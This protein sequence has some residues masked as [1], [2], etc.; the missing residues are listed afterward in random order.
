MNAREFATASLRGGDLEGMGVK[1]Y[2]LRK[3]LEM[4]KPRASVIMPYKKHIF[5][6]DDI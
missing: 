2:T 5:I 1:G 4:D 3:T 6:L